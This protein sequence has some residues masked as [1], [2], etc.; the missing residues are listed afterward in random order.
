MVLV[1]LTRATFG[2]VVRRYVAGRLTLELEVVG[3]DI[4]EWLS[5]SFVQDGESIT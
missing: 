5:G 2:V 1:A 4:G 3:G